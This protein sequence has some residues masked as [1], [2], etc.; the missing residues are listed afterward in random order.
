[1]YSEVNPKG[2]NGSQK[3]AREIEKKIVFFSLL[4]FR[5]FATQTETN[6]REIE[7]DHTKYY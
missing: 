1:M 5:S 6:G 7:K 4:S 3:W 2:K